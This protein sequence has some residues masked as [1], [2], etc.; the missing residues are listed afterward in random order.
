M[1]FIAS[2]GFIMFSS[3]HAKFH[4]PKTMN[5]FF[6]FGALSNSNVEAKSKNEYTSLNY[7]SRKGH[8]EIVKHLYEKNLADVETKDK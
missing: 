3:F 7:A 1:I 5:S 8:I 2:T 6:Y 4:R